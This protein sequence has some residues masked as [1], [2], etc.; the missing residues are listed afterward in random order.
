MPCQEKVIFTDIYDSKL[1]FTWCARKYT[2]TIIRLSFWLLPLL[3]PTENT[4]EKPQ[5]LSVK[6]LIDAA[7]RLGGFSVFGLSF[8]LVLKRKIKEK[9]ALLCYYMPIL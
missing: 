7:E 9:N 8:F 5:K 1:F 6:N 2:I 3:R 4:G